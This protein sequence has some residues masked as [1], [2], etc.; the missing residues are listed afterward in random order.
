MW[1]PKR[2][3]TDNIQNRLTDLREQTYYGCQGE[4]TVREFGTDMYTLLY[5]KW[6]TNKELLYGAWNYAQCSM[7]AYLGGEFEVEWIHVYIWLNP[8]AV[9]LSYYSTVNWLCLNTK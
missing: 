6:I 4:E 8:S 9:H 2:H 7:A 1:N 5:L 3:D